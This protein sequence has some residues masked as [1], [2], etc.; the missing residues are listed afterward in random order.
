MGAKDDEQPTQLREELDRHR[1]ELATQN[2]DLRR[3]N[4]AL[5]SANA[6]YALLYER[7]PVAY[8]T[9]DGHRRVIELNGAASALLRASS[10]ELVGIA[11]DA[12]RGRRLDEIVVPASRPAFRAFH[13]RLVADGERQIHETVLE[14]DGRRFRARLEAVRFDSEEGGA[15]QCLL[16]ISDETERQRVAEE[17]RQLEA[18][19]AEAFRVESLGLLAGGIAHDFRNVLGL[20]LGHLALAAPHAKANAPLQ[21]SL[22]VV[23]DALER[24]GH[25]SRQLL[26]YA[27]GTNLQV[28]ALD[29]S[30]LIAS[31]QALLSTAAPPGTLTFDLAAD[32]PPV[33]AEHVPL[34]QIV[35]NL[36]VNAGDA[37]GPDGKIVVRTRRTEMLGNGEMP[38]H[39]GVLIEVEDNGRGMDAATQS[40]AFDP[41]FSTKGAGRGIGLSV[42][43]GNVR[44]HGG[45]VTIE[46]KPNRGTIL[47]VYLPASPTPIERPPAVAEDESSWKASGL[48]LVVDDNV[49]LRKVMGQLVRGF[50]FDTCFAGDG[51]EAIAI[52][53]ERHGELVAVLLDVAMPGMGGEEALVEIKRLAASLPVI[54]MSGLSRAQISLGATTSADGFLEKPFTLVELRRVMEGALSRYAAR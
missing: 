19:V 52:V 53:R 34:Q 11:R 50:G 8:V 9:L 16:C 23:R 7:A 17:R 38:P 37:I 30:N 13:E 44:V 36:V 28:E 49:V 43:Q 14:S 26:A 10:P 4:A 27:G 21:E 1:E 35:L 47:R 12:V 25:L 6:R 29:V 46:S 24:A 31:T 42:V 15:S 54:L 2:E 41:F 51:H 33:L 40:R 3:A 32:L 39:G 45:S 22:N 48:V 20:A 18:K 5:V